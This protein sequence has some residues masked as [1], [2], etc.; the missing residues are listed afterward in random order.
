MKKMVKF[1]SNTRNTNIPLNGKPPFCVKVNT[2]KQT[3]FLSD[4]RIFSHQWAS[5][6]LS[7]M[8]SSKPKVSYFGNLWLIPVILNSF[9]S[10]KKVIVIII[11][12]TIVRIVIIIKIVSLVSLLSIYRIV[13]NAIIVRIIIIFTKWPPPWSS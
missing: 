13:I 9:I 3:M 6:F 12:V 8:P 4:G 5:G 2:N 7:W 1:N 11:V 10:I